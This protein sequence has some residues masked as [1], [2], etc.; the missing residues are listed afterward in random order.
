MI[1]EKNNIISVCSECTDKQQKMVQQNL[2]TNLKQLWLESKRMWVKKKF[3]IT[4]NS[5]YRSEM[6]WILVSDIDFENKTV[7]GTLDNKPIYIN[8]VKF[9]DEVIVKFA[10][11]CNIAME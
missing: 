1:N 7:K 11:I 5:M 10:E 9:G 6:M 8:E 3:K 4:G 2:E